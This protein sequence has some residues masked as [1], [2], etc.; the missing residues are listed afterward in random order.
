MSP[1]LK[2][3]HEV[4]PIMTDD[5]SGNHARFNLTDEESAVKPIYIKPSSQ[6]LQKDDDSPVFSDS[7]DF[8]P[9]KEKDNMNPGQRLKQQLNP[10]QSSESS[11][12]KSTLKRQVHTLKNQLNDFQ[13]EG[14]ELV[15]FNKELQWT[16]MMMKK[17]NDVMRDNLEFLMNGGDPKK[18][19]QEQVEKLIGM[20]PDKFK[21]PQADNV[22]DM[23]SEFQSDSAGIKRF[24]DNADSSV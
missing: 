9:S 3:D 11:I 1:V 8:K 21:T 17:D 22:F 24:T 20:S 13:A 18:L 23:H 7:V 14:E 15:D 10:E 16:L 4:S 12:N 19:E 2:N 6:S 5:K